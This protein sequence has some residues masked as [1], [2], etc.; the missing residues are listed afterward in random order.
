M[1]VLLGY[2]IGKHIYLSSII[3]IFIVLTLKSILLKLD[4][5]C[6]LIFG[7]FFFGDIQNCTNN[8]SFGVMTCNISFVFDHSIIYKTFNILTSRTTTLGMYSVLKSRLIADWSFENI[9]SWHVAKDIWANW[10]DKRTGE[11]TG[12]K[13]NNL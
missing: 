4:V 6:I 8:I 9:N 2:R 1:I 3:Y 12:H 7:G 11:K 5:F 13:S 10:Q